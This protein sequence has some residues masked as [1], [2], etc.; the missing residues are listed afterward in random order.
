MEFFINENIGSKFALYENFSFLNNFSMPTFT[1]FSFTNNVFN[2]D[3]PFNSQVISVYPS[4]SVSIFGLGKQSSFD[5][6]SFMT[7]PSL[8]ISMN[9]TSHYDNKILQK[10]EKIYDNT[11]RAVNTSS[12]NNFSKQNGVKKISINGSDVYACRWSNFT[13]SKKEWLDLQKYMIESAEELGLTLV[14]SDMDRT[15]AASNAGRAKKGNLVAKGGQSPHNYGVAAD[16]CL[17]KKGKA[18]NPNSPE[19]EEFA[20]LVKQKSDNCIAWGGDWTKKGE[21]HHF[22]LQ[23]WRDK[24]KNSENLIC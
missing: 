19:F 9:R 22:E 24:Y 18:L 7:K 23:G 16:I 17:F 5:C 2:W 12:W 4:F 15:V 14:Y 21:R 8:D 10:Q 6:F 13:K 20:N 3:F 11:K 1:N